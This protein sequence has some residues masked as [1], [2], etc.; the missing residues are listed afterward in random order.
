MNA[1]GLVSAEI[2]ALELK[3]CEA[4]ARKSIFRPMPFEDDDD[5]EG[6]Q[7]YDTPSRR[8]TPIGKSQGGTMITVALRP[9]PEQ[10][11]QA[12]APFFRLFLDDDEVPPASTAPQG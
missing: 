5:G 4:L 12:L 3:K 11:R 10:R 2:A 6:I 7:V 1:R 8:T 9:S